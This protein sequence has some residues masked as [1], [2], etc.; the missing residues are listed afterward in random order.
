MAGP[1]FGG[2]F[3]GGGF[4]GSAS[5]GVRGSKGKKPPVLRYSEIENRE[6]IG[7]FLKSQLKLRHPDSAFTD[8]SAQDAENARKAAR[9]LA[10]QERREKEMRRRA[11]AEAARFAK[12]AEQLEADQRRM[13]ALQNDNLRTLIM[14]ASA[15]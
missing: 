1:F 6:D 12:S 10:K 9:A 2:A 7:Q 14:I 11:D 3:F 8:T 13:V 5:A 15:V 4:F